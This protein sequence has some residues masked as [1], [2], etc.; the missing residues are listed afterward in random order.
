M[1]QNYGTSEEIPAKLISIFLR[2]LNGDDTYVKLNKK[3]QGCYRIHRFHMVTDLNGD[4]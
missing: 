4:R 1:Q 2:G 3:G